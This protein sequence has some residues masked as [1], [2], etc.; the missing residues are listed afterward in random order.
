[1]LLNFPLQH[2]K[3]PCICLAFLQTSPAGSSEA[4]A[5]INS[6]ARLSGIHLITSPSPSGSAKCWPTI[7]GF[8]LCQN[9]PLPDTK[10][11]AIYCCRTNYFKIF[12]FK[13]YTFIISMDQEPG[14]DSLVSHDH[15]LGL[16]FWGLRRAGG[17]ASNM[18]LPRDC[19]QQD[20]ALHHRA[21][22]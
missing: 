9:P 17:S 10:I 16:Q 6:Y 13:Q 22:P 4:P 15:H 14:V 1:M 8:F 7:L 2:N 18:V 20:S 11:S 3:I 5:A 21:S 19:W 12:W